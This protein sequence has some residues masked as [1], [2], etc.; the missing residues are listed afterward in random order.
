MIRLLPKYD[1]LIDVDIDMIFTDTNEIT[2]N[3]IDEKCSVTVAYRFH[4]SEVASALHILKNN[5]F[6]NQ[7]LKDI[8]EY[9]KYFGN[10]NS[11]VDYVIYKHVCNL[12]NLTCTATQVEANGNLKTKFNLWRTEFHNVYFRYYYYRQK[13][14]CIRLGEESI[15]KQWELKH[16]PKDSVQLQ[17]AYNFDWSNSW[18]SMIN[19]QN[20]LLHTKSITIT[21]DKQIIVDNEDLYMEYFKMLYR[22]DFFPIQSLN[23]II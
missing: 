21:N 22:Y 14:I 5:E 19:K 17:V 16:V 11:A 23:D 15:W 4:N 1:Y 2:H 6:A 7:Y 3:F 8:Y 10:D 18:W 9:S 13:D 12:Y 20:L